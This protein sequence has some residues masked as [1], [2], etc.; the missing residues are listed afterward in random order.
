MTSEVF[1]VGPLPPPV[2]GF[3]LI[4]QR[5]LNCLL[6]KTRVTVFDTS[7]KF[8]VAS[9]GIVRILGILYR[10]FSIVRF[11]FFVIARRPTSFYLG[12][13]G[14]LGQI[15]DSFYILIARIF[16]AKIFV[17]HHSFAYLNDK[18]LYNRICLRLTGEACHIVLCDIMAEQLFSGYG[19][20]NGN[21]YIL[22]NVAF[23]QENRVL[24][25]KRK[26]ETPVLTLGF[27]SNITIE[28]GIVEY[29]EVIAR[30]G[31]LNVEIK[32]VVAGP[33]DPLLKDRFS[34][35]LETYSKVEY[36]G[37]I[38]GEE[39]ERFFQNINLLLF[40][41]K[42]KNEAEPV[43]ILEA[44][45]FGVPVIASKRGC[46]SSIVSERSGLIVFDHDQYV[47][48]ATNFVESLATGKASI[49]MISEGALEQFNELRVRNAN[50]LD[51]LVARIIGN[52]MP[53]H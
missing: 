2:G 1:F 20:L 14:G 15:F 26:K 11:L 4:N 47:A 19:I 24:N 16:G 41:T 43:T 5:M 40:P 34:S 6:A 50:R 37:P 38:Y 53:A 8:H 18:K 9:A 44:L 31:Q 36:L 39:K 49:E 48:E 28:K 25:I 21:I 51:E 52:G 10:P 29:F 46:I 12:L 32:A 45:S 13:S 23:L 3:S 35:M 22:S 27:L 42:Y 30:L 17:H 7:P 33:V